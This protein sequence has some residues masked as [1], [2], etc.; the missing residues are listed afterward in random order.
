M[1]RVILFIQRILVDLWMRIRH[2]HREI[3]EERVE[4]LP[5][6]LWRNVQ[7]IAVCWPSEGMDISA[8]MLILQRLRERFPNASITVIALPG[9]GASIPVGWDVEVINVQKTDLNGL[10]FPNSRFRSYLRERNYDTFLDLYPRYDPICVYYG[11]V[12]CA[13]LRIGF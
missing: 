9:V 1:D 4:G 8:A 6:R 3:E 11:F 12:I 2:L 13:R 7:R 10:R 5:N